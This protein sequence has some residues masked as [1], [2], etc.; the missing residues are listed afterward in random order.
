MKVLAEDQRNWVCNTAN[1]TSL[2]WYMFHCR[3]GLECCRQLGRI[4]RHNKVDPTQLILSSFQG[5]GPARP[6]RS[7]PASVEPLHKPRQLWCFKMLRRFPGILPVIETTRARSSFQSWSTARWIC[8]SL[9]TI[10]GTDG[11]YNG[12]VIDI[13]CVEPGGLGN[14]DMQGLEKLA[15]L[16]AECCDW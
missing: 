13:D 11:I 2:L 10:E 3:S 6:L 12:G 16:L 15:K 4:S 9:G 5:M 1:A 14:D 7:V 8:R